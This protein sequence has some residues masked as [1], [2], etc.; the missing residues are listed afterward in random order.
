M[1]NLNNLTL[2]QALDSLKNK[3]I[4]LEELYTDL[5]SA[6]EQKNDQLK[7]YLSLKKNSLALAKEAQ[8]KNLPLLGLPIAV[9]DNFCTVDLP[10]TASAKLLKEYISPYES[11]VTSKLKKAGAVVIGK[12]N[13]D[14]W[15]HGSSTETSEFGTTLNPCNPQYLPGGSSGG[16]SASVAGDLTLGAIGSETAGSIRQPSAWCG[17]VGLK[18]TYGRVSRYG[19]IAMAS[20]I[21]TPGPITKTVEDASLLFNAIAG[22]DAKDATSSRVPPPDLTSSLDQSIKGLKIGVMYLEINGLEKIAP[23]YQEQL[24]VFKE[25]GATVEPVQ[26][27]DPSYAIGVYTVIQ[28][29]E[30]SSNLARFDGIRFGHDRS[31]FGAEAKRRIMLG[32][33]TLSKGYAEQYYNLAQKIRTLF[34]QDF[35]QLFTK[36]DV[37]VAPTSPGY[38]K[39]LG[40]SEGATMF[41][42]LEDM[43]L[44]ASSVTGLPGISVPCYR[45]DDTNLYLG[46]NIMAPMF[47]EE[48]LIKVADAFEKN[49]P[50]NSWRSRS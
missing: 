32:T 10:T 24:K 4:S 5:L 29:G 44:E 25:L 26:A 50:W 33:F 41:G 38:A 35:Q 11:T 12:T 42:E 27:L 14:A 20:S 6:I 17:T 13:L 23:I 18:P 39:K 34:I 22:H 48:T 45:D 49:T 21:D 28:R 16:S 36:Y 7:I 47:K 31:L 37:L 8:E 40:V 19:L 2:K 1:S 15:A 43:L 3:T 30:V 46:L 9:K